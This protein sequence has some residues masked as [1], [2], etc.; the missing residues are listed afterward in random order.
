[1]ESAVPHAVSIFESEMK[2]DAKTHSNEIDMQKSQWMLPALVLQAENP[3]TLN[4]GF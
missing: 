2:R 3:P 4:D 1:M